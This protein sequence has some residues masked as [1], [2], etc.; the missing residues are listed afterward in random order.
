MPDLNSVPA[1]PF[2]VS[3]QRRLS[4]A[5]AMPPLAISTSP[6]LNILPS[7]Q[8]TVNNAGTAAAFPS[9][10][11]PSVAAPPIAA[12]GGTGDNSGVGIGPG[13]LRHPRPLT[14][15][16]LHLQMEKEQEAVVN[17]LTRELSLVRA[18][19]N[20][21]VVSNASSTSAGGGGAEP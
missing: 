17:R 2:P 10:P 5:T 7:N 16:D 15:A 20:A 4:N 19:H 13:P 3:G 8:N 14:A 12:T 6:S 11:L 18:A 21:S 1:S 9:P